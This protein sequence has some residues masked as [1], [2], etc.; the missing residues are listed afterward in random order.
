MITNEYEVIS[1]FLSNNFI[2]LQ[3]IKLHNHYFTST[4]DLLYQLKMILLYF[5]EMESANENLEYEKTLT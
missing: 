1:V 2:N 4:V 5:F 3:V